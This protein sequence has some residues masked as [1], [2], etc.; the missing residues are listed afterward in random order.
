MSFKFPCDKGALT[1]YLYNEMDEP[2][3][4]QTDDHLGQCAECTAEVA[5]LFGVRTELS[6]WVPP[7]AELR[8]TRV[9]RDATPD[10]SP[11][12]LGSAPWWSRV[13]VWAQ[14]VAAILVL[15]VSAA[16]A[17][18]QV[19]SGPDGFVVSTGWL[20]PAAVTPAAG[21]AIGAA[22]NEQW[23]TALIALERQL[24]QEIQANRE[25]RTV[26][27]VSRPEADEA[28]VKRVRDLLDASESR[29]NHQLALRV[30]QLTRDMDI[31]R[32]AD[33]LRIEQGIGHTGVEIAK[34]RQ[35]LNYVIRA[36]NTPQQ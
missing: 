7:D 32:R 23:K 14:V 11:L 4:Q 26:N 16:I 17:N 8:F 22:T 35:M 5:A 9:P 3:R 36:S 29:Q 1:A 30:T 2:Q 19:R 13:P 28:T 27:A 25:V 21:P 20:T 31:Q 12:V 33:L 34:Q 6:R 24:R 18:L 10:V 15:A